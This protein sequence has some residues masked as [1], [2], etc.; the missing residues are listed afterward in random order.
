MKRKT[1]GGEERLTSNGRM[2]EG[3]PSS[4]DVSKL[5]LLIVPSEFIPFYALTTDGRTDG[6]DERHFLLTF[7]I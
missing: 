5:Y 6:L 3:R 2:E 1:T 7:I 4:T